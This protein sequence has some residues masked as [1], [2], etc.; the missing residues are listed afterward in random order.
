MGILKAVPC[1][2]KYTLPEWI[3]ARRAYKDTLENRVNRF[4]EAVSLAG[5]VGAPVDAEARQR[6]E[7]SEQ[8]LLVLNRLI[9]LIGAECG[10]YQGIELRR[11]LERAQELGGLDDAKEFAELDRVANYWQK[12]FFEDL[13]ITRYHPRGGSIIIAKYQA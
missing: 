11:N 10:M 4:R 8:K 9:S 2:D 5:K 3:A 7:K 1:E 13:Q 6:L 12:F